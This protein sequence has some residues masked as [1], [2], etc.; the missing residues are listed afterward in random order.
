MKDCWCLI[1]LFH[2]SLLLELLRGRTFIRM[3]EKSEN[4]WKFIMRIFVCL[5]P[6]QRRYSCI[7][8]PPSSLV[9]PVKSIIISWSEVK[10]KPS[11][12]ASLVLIINF[13]KPRLVH[14]HPTRRISTEKFS[15]LKLPESELY[16]I[17]KFISIVKLW[18]LQKL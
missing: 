17:N 1:T 8:L 10:L 18:I 7:Y 12:N 13:L 16:S 11:N 15:C 14:F 3:K 4:G 6:H 9:V 2:N 5:L